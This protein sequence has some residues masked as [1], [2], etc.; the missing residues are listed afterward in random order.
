MRV[1]LTVFV[2]FCVATMLSQLIGLALAWS[3]GS[4]Q[5]ANVE[6]AIAVLAGQEPRPTEP[7]KIDEEPMRVTEKQWLEFRASR[8]LDL[9]HRNRELDGRTDFVSDLLE[10][11]RAE[12]AALDKL[13]AEF[14]QRLQQIEQSETDEGTEKVRSILAK[15]KPSQAKEILMKRDVGEAVRLLSG[16]PE[17]TVAKLLKEFKT[18]EEMAR[19]EEILRLLDEGKQ[20]GQAAR[21]TQE[22][23]ANVGR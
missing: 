21:E 1:A 17:R 14:E 9:D 12:R 19:A 10:K 11:V 3:T 6:K 5:P 18:E 7:D 4:L 20:Q 16:M 22:E 13:R 8:D 15:V 2:S 23:L